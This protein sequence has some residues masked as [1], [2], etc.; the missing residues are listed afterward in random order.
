MQDKVDEI[1][2]VNLVLNKNNN[3]QKINRFL[4]NNIKNSVRG[5]QLSSENSNEKMIA[6]RRL[7]TES[8]D[9]KKMK[10]TVTRIKNDDVN[11]VFQLFENSSLE[12][13][14]HIAR[15]FVDARANFQKNIILENSYLEKEGRQRNFELSSVKFQKNYE[16]QL[17]KMRKTS[18]QLTN[19]RTDF[20]L[21][22]KTRNIN[23]KML[24]RRSS[25]QDGGFKQKKSIPVDPL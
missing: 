15:A 22:A 19:Y 23:I 6:F 14:V 16:R 9:K 12:N 8:L 4:T 3:P 20:S 11:K 17:S 18:K 1:T 2:N 7:N 21:D 24:S 25:L 10:S 13:S 5:S